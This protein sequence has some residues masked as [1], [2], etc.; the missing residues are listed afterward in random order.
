MIKSRRAQS[1]LE[2]VIVLTAIVAAVLAAATLIGNSDQTR[3]VGKIM[4]D[5]GERIKAESGQIATILND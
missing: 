1:T 4:Y 3:G 5:S 2:Y